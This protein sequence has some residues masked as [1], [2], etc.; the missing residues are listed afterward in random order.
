MVAPSAAS[1]AGPAPLVAGVDYPATWRDFRLQFP[2]DAACAAYLEQLRWRDGFRCP[3][4]QSTKGWRT[5][6][7]RWSCGGC[8]RRVSVT[9]GTVFDRT[10][11]PLAEWFAAAWYVTNQKHGASALGLQRVLGFGSYQTAWAM[12][13]KLRTAM[14]RPGRDGL[15]GEVEVDETF[16][17]GVAHGGKRGRAAA[18]KSI[19]VIAV[20]VLSPKGFGRVR[21]RCVPNASGASLVPFVCDVVEPGSTV[22]TDGW[23]GYD[24]LFRKGYT[25]RQ[26]AI[27]ATGDPAHVS[28]PAVHRVASLLKRWLLG[29]HQGSVDPVHLQAYLDEFTFR[30]NRRSS[31]RRGML[32]YRL[33]ELAVGA[34]PA[35]YRTLVGRP[36]R[37]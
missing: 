25:H 34:S 30:F 37:R 4:C 1:P 3:R 23:R 11:T 5:A 2:D 15:K 16:V 13:H 8:A 6:D 7:A 20:E 17:G 12:L 22:L 21:M 18:R 29:T 19:V 24:E 33:L 31:R 28:L 14:V 10:R 35:P 9:A 27:S 36:R 32:F 26:I